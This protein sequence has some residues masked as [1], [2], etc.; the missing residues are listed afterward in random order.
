MF[1][2]ICCCFLVAV[3]IAAAVVSAGNDTAT[4]ASAENDI[5]TIDVATLHGQHNLNESDLFNRIE[6]RLP[7]NLKHTVHIL[8]ANAATFRQNSHGRDQNDWN[9]HINQ[10]L[11][12]FDIAPLQVL[13]RSGPLLS[14]LA[15]MGNH[16]AIEHGPLVSVIMI[17]YNAE[18]TVAYACASILGQTWHSLELIIVDDCSTD[19]TWQALKDIEMSDSRVRLLQNRV[20][21]GPYVSKNMALSTIRGMYI[22]THDADDWAHPHRIEVQVNDIIRSQGTVRANMIQMLRVQDNGYITPLN[23][24]SFSPDGA[25]RWAYISPMFEKEFLKDII[26]HWDSVWYGADSEI[27]GRTQ[28]ILG[29][30]FH[31][32]GF[33][34]ILCRDREG[35]LGKQGWDSRNDFSLNK[36]SDTRNFDPF[37]NRHQYRAAL[38]QW[39]K[40]DISSVRNFPLEFPLRHRPFPVPQDMAVDIETICSNLPGYTENTGVNIGTACDKGPTYTRDVPRDCFFCGSTSLLGVLG[41]VQGTLYYIAPEKAPSWCATIAGGDPMML[42]PIAGLALMT[43]MYWLRLK[44]RENTFRVGSWK[45]FKFT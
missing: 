43:F 33:V 22:T 6:D 24:S 39:H 8:R 38:S 29:E 32:L 28:R 27:I 7:E 23:V 31:K 9:S 34:G 30:A 26:G 10:Y 25:A 2:S 16:S 18:D 37:S 41:R 4:V 44:G 42:W 13:D 40:Q 15:S 45:R 3:R 14:R 19:N 20:R 11:K 5:P 36:T 12:H 1:S 17:S 21:V 35:S